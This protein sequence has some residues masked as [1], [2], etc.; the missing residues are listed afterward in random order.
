M[1]RSGTTTLA[2]RAGSEQI[3]VVGTFDEIAAD[4]NKIELFATGLYSFFLTG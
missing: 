3:L 4:H 2:S 1:A